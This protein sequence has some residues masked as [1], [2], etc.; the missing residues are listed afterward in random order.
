MKKYTFHI[1]MAKYKMIILNNNTLC[2]NKD[3]I[4]KL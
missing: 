2:E 3:F 4:L 1:E